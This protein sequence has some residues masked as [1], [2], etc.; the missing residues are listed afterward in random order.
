VGRERREEIHLVRGDT[1]WL[2]TFYRERFFS[3]FLGVAETGGGEEHKQFL[4]F[5][6]FIYRLVGW[7]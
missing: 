4:L 6:L 5:Y 2:S 1:H 7:P 3:G